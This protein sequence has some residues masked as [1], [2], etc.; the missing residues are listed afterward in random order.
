MHLAKRTVG[1][2]SV[3]ARSR[4]RREDVRPAAREP[5]VSGAA[6]SVASTAT[7]STPHTRTG[8]VIEST[9]GERRMR[10]VDRRMDI[11]P[12]WAQIPSP[13]RIEEP[14]QRGLASRRIRQSTSQGAR[15]FRWTRECGKNPSRLN[16]EGVVV[17]RPPQGG[18]QRHRS[19]HKGTD[20]A[21]GPAGVFPFARCAG[22][23][24]PGGVAEWLARTTARAPRISR[25]ETNDETHRC[26]GMTRRDGR[27]FPD[28]RCERSPRRPDPD[29][30]LP[31]RTRRGSRR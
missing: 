23:T 29:S 24:R 30:R 22:P 19:D 1:G 2:R 10:A 4:D 27:L 13:S 16:G 18:A 6:R 3:T 12:I 21:A 20:D 17:A 7:R 14:S 5:C 25:T 15:P 9:R 28:V 31:A 8:V 26:A 11:A